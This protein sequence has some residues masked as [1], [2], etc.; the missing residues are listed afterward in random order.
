MKTYHKGIDVVPHDTLA[1]L[2]KGQAVVPKKDNTM[3][4]ADWRDGVTGK[5]RKPKKEIKRMVHEKSHNGGHIITHEHHHPEHHPDEKHTFSNMADVAAHMEKHAG[6]P[7]DGEAP[8]AGAA[9]MTAS[10]SPMPSP[11]AGAAAGGAAP[12]VPGM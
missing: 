10:P 11:D 9:P 12:A 2:Q 6:T 3:A 8:D 7:N 4:H 1:H 5:D